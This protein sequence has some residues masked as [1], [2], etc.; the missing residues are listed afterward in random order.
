RR[1][2]GRVGGLQGR[3]VLTGGNVMVFRVLLGL[4]AFVDMRSYVA[5]QQVFGRRRDRGDGRGGRGRG[6]RRDR[7]GGGRP[8]GDRRWGEG[9]PRGHDEPRMAKRRR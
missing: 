3:E 1:P 4:I 7:R 2:G 6:D 9:R 8:R 5:D